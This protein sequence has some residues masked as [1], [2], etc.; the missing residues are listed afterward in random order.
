M[1]I[2]LGRLIHP[3]LP[4]GTVSKTLS[5]DIILVICRNSYLNN[6][7]ASTRW[8]FAFTII[9][10]RPDLL[11]FAQSSD[12][13][14]RAVTNQFKGLFVSRLVWIRHRL[15]ETFSSP[16]NTTGGSKGLRMAKAAITKSLCW[17][18]G[19][20]WLNFALGAMSRICQFGI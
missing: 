6:C 5:H 7:P 10:Q 20:K 1:P 4:S 13:G 19:G 8:T 17:R 14:E 11:L 3:P 9:D 15:P 16:S 18:I 2:V 12:H